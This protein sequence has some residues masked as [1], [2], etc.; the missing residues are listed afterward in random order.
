M[1]TAVMGTGGVADIMTGSRV[2]KAGWAGVRWE[3]T[4]FPR[5]IW[6]VST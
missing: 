3:G 1:R 4:D 2:R 6:Q 5:E